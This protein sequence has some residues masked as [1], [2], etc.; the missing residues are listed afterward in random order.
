MST[1]LTRKVLLYQQLL[2]S[3]DKRDR[4]GRDK[5]FRSL[6]NTCHIFFYTYPVKIRMLKEE[7]ASELLIYVAPRIP[8][9]I[10]TFRYERISFDLYLRKIAYLQTKCFLKRK[11]RNERK[12]WYEFTPINDIED[13]LASDFPFPYEVMEATRVERNPDLNW[14]TETKASE[15]VRKKIRH[16][17]IFRRRF[18]LLILLSCDAL[19]AQHIAFLAEYLG[20]GEQE[21]ASLISRTHECSIDKRER[22]RHLAGIRNMHFC[23]KMFYQ[24]ELEMMESFNADP[25]FLEPVRRSLAYEE[26]YFK[27]RCKEVQDRPNSITHRQLA[28]LS[29]IPKGTVDSGLSTIRNFLDGIM[30]GSG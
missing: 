21:L 22:T 30:D 6:V 3:K 27:Q 7:D 16:S 1:D 14:S 26:Y 29:G 15:L 12:I 17:K 28:L 19:S 13:C 18:I 2:K 10:R 24:R 5:L 11:K 25:L 9:M 4:D 8:T 20:M 23:R